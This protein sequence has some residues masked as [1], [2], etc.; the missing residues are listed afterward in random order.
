MCGR[1]ARRAPRRW[2]KRARMRALAP[3]PEEWFFPDPCD[4]EKG[5]DK[6]RPYTRKETLCV[7]AGFIPAQENLSS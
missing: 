1:K 3:L 7:G 4:G 6:P 2:C 5:G